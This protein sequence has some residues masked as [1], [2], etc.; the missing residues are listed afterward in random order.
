[1]EEDMDLLNILID[2]DELDDDQW[3]ADGAPK[4]SFLQKENGGSVSR[5]DVINAAPHF[6]RENMALPTDPE[7]EPPVDEE[8]YPPKPSIEISYPTNRPLP[9][10]EFLRLLSTVGT[11][12]L[13]SLQEIVQ[14][15]KI[16]F[17]AEV[18]KLKG[19]IILVSRANK[20]IINR[21]AAEKPSKTNQEEIMD[22]VRKQGEIRAAKHGAVSELLKGID[23]KMLD[24][25][26]PLD[27]A[28]AR[29][30]TRGTQRPQR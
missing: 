26:A 18:E 13:A 4:L 22:Y 17:R 30:T 28:M 29:K 7:P 14:Q 8:P 12:D 6:T 2:M 16:D 20:F 27:R 23:P 9:E 11:D 5:Q 3:T 25:R 24:P 10:H 21:L 19:W 1:M 15:Q